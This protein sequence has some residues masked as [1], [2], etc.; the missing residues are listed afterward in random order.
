MK[1][2]TTA[3]MAPIWHPWKAF[4]RHGDNWKIISNLEKQVKHWKSDLK[5]KI[6]KKNEMQVEFLFSF[7]DGRV[8]M[9]VTCISKIFKS[10]LYLCLCGTFTLSIYVCHYRASLIMNYCSLIEIYKELNKQ[11]SCIHNFIIFYILLV[12]SLLS[13]SSHLYKLC[14]NCQATEHG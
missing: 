14:E 11:Y 5:A 10:N 7:E 1:Y 12:L 4:W 2:L 3:I 13:Q 6:D 9:H 8:T